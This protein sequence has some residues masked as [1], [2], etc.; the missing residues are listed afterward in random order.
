VIVVDQPTLCTTREK[1]CW[2]F[3][4][5]HNYLMAICYSILMF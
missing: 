3:E 4:W 1:Y 5:S 2:R